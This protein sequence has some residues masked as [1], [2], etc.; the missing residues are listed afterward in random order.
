MR[1]KYKLIKSLACFGITLM[2]GTIVSA[3]TIVTKPP[4]TNDYPTQERVEYVFGCMKRYGG[5]NY[6]TMYGCV[7]AIDKIATQITFNDFIKVQT[8][9]VI[10]NTP[11]E[12]G[13]AFRDIEGGRESIR[14]FKAFTQAVEQEDCGLKKPA[15][16][17][18]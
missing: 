10:I 2:F 16:N 4:Q 1:V 13:G 18:L 3:D 6:N 17:R 15:A 11:G 12:K 8:L 7:C 14:N 5:D 9:S